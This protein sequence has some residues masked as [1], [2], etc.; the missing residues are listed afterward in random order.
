MTTQSDT[1]EPTTAGRIMPVVR[2]P[3][4]YRPKCSRCQADDGSWWAMA[5]RVEDSRNGL[6]IGFED[7][8]LKFG[9]ERDATRA[10]DSFNEAFADGEDIGVPTCTDERLGFMAT[11][12]LAW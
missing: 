12:Y 8:D 1:Q 11:R 9:N 2:V 3:G 10:C 6:I 5:W 7:R 4:P